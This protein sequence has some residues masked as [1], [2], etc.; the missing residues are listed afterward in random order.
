MRTNFFGDSIIESES[1]DLGDILLEAGDEV[2]AV[3]RSN[4]GEESG[5]F[6][7]EIMLNESGEIVASSDP[8]FDN[9]EAAGDY[10]RRWITDVQ[11]D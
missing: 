3:V 5:K 9:Q 1:D 7:F 11:F 2:Y 4:E 6:D 8:I 10:L